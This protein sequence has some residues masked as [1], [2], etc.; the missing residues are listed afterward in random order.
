[1]SKRSCLRVLSV[2]YAPKRIP[3]ITQ[4]F[5][6][7]FPGSDFDCDDLFIS[8]NV[9][10]IVSHWNDG[11]L[12]LIQIVNFKNDITTHISGLG[13]PGPELLASSSSE[14]Y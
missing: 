11:S 13:I 3:V 2:D 7:T 8:Q 12:P 5:L 1:M 4:V 10:G 14:F 9:I 6:Q